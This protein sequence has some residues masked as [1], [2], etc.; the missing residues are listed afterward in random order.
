LVLDGLLQEF[1]K[2]NLCDVTGNLDESSNLDQLLFISR[3]LANG[4][5]HIDESLLD[6]AHSVIAPFLN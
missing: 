5:F 1:L 3:D 4:R 6:V 2:L